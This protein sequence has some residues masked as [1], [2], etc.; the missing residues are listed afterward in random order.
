MQGGA[1]RWRGGGGGHQ[2]TGPLDQ[3]HGG[4]EEGGGREHLRHRRRAV[5]VERQTEREE[6]KVPGGAGLRG[7]A[8]GPGRR[9]G[10]GGGQ[11][12]AGRGG[13]QSLVGGECRSARGGTPNTVRGIGQKCVVDASLT[14]FHS[15]KCPRFPPGR[16]DAAPRRCGV[17]APFASGPPPPLPPAPQRPCHPLG[18][19]RCS[20]VCVRARRVRGGTGAR[21]AAVQ[22]ELHTERQPAPTAVHRK[23]PARRFPPSVRPL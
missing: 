10:G 16:Q 14:C 18:S 23:N 20:L 15:Y 1:I 6:V 12:A 17:V 11:A 22:Q 19:A 4:L 8:R 9:N 5:G 2:R 21:V 3:E 13:D 7:G